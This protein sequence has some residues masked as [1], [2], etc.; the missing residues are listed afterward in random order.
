MKAL[1]YE[2]SLP[3]LAASR[4]A[5][6][7]VPGRGARVG[8]LRLAS[9][10]E[11]ERP[12]PD[13][14]RVRPL[15]AGI[16]GSDLATLDGHGSR[17]FE[18]LV[19]FPFVPGHEVV[20]R[21]DDGARVVLEPVLG[22][23]ARDVQP[24]CPACARGDTGDCERVAFGHLRPGLQTGYCADTGGG[25][26]GA[27]VA[28][29]SQLHAVPDGLSDHDAV[30]VEPTACAVHG[31]LRAVTEGALVI[32]IGA[33]TL[34]L[35]TVAAVRRLGLPGTLMAV[36]KH[37]DQRRLAAELGA[38][39]V[40]EPDGVRRAVRLQTRSLSVDGRL[41]GGADVVIDCVGSARSLTHALAVVRPRGQVVLL[42]M[43]EPFRV[44][45]TP[46]WHREVALLGAY[47]YGSEAP[48]AGRAA[49]R[50]FALAFELVADAGLG[51]LVSA[52]YPLE[53][54]REAIEH[55]AAAGRRG[56][57]KVAFDLRA[58][59]AASA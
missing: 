48:A 38:D 19:S 22:C 8:P 54:Y 43:P 29:R 9:V 41:T 30:M 57:V 34:G 50:T 39:V 45:L 49:T 2:R 11:P 58:T 17:Y 42:G 27:L 28:H 20:G 3:K 31:A 53:R 37:P 23:Q 15:L 4:V 52:T 59:K 10:D 7:F 32:V 14:V 13:W 24:P 44:D 33:G 51:R 46:L 1:L 5:G 47:A 6:S 16:C 18:A 56:G 21:L 40:V 12:G 36:A 55:A 26:S 35:C 25:W